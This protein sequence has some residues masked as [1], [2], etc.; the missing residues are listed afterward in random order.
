MIYYVAEL[1]NLH[2]YRMAEKIE[3]KN[4]RAA[5]TYASR[6]QCFYNTVL[7]IGM[8][9]TSAGYIDRTLPFSY[10]DTGNK[11]DNSWHDEGQMR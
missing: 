7:I 5:K 4:L 11:S 3:A 1:E 10:K 2:S 6:N 8:G 9:I